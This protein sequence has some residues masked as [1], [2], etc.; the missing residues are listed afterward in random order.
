[1]LRLRG[2]AIDL[3]L[4][5]TLRCGWIHPYDLYYFDICLAHTETVVGYLDL[6][7]GHSTYLYYLGNIGYRID[8]AYRGHRYALQACRLV[9]PFAKELGMD[10][11]LITC[12]PDNV[13]SRKTLEHLGGEL[14][15][16]ATVPRTHYLYR[17]HERVKCIYRYP[18][19]N[20]GRTQCDMEQVSNRE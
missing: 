20:G 9:L 12:D 17:N 8:E 7:V 11:I 15:E 18:L 5:Y 16:V 10:Y 2:E 1:M 3:V 6:R 13:P 4:R 19:T 14:L